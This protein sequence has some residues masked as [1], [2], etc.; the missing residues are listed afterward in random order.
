MHRIVR[1]FPGEISDFYNVT[2]SRSLGR[3]DADPL[4]ADAIRDPLE[5]STLTLHITGESYRGAKARKL[6][7]KKKN[8]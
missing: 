2:T 3:G 4:I 5:L 7:S 8:D 1:A 6:V